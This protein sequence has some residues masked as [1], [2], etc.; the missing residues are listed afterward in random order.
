MTGYTT[1]VSKQNEA[2]VK[3]QVAKMK[4]QALQE[5]RN[6]LQRFDAAHS[7]PSSNTVKA[8]RSLWAKD[9]NMLEN[10]QRECT[11]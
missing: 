2:R 5:A 8:M 4:D 1:I 10:V 6:G 11:A 7:A 9:V 3:E